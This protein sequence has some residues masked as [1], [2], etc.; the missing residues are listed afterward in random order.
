MLANPYRAFFDA[1][2][3]ACRGAA[4]PEPQDAGWQAWK[5]WIARHFAWAVPTDAAV[6]RIAAHGG[7]VVEIGCGSGY[8]AWLLAQA[9]VDVAAYD[10]DPP[11]FVWHSVRAGDA[12]AAALHPDRALLLCWPPYGAGVATRALAA[13]AG[14]VVAY[15]GEWP[16]GCAEPA[17]FTALAQ[18]WQAVDGAA[19]PNW[20]GRRDRLTIFRR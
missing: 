3:P 16:G 2:P 12:A 8:W 19:L 14:P 5:A 1:L 7:R 18:G 4:L 17:F 9:G 13:Y 10:P 20:C 6:A 15:V 11:D